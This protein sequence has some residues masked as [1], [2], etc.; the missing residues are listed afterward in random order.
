MI[1]IIDLRD[2]RDVG[3]GFVGVGE[4]GL[5]VELD[6]RGRVG[7]YIFVFVGVVLFSLVVSLLLERS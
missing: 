6:G 3:V 4:G 7:E 5:R 1:R 2:M